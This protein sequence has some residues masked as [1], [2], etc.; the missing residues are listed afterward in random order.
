MRCEPLL[1]AALGRLTAVGQLCRLWHVPVPVVRK[2]EAV[3]YTKAVC[4]KSSAAH[5]KKPK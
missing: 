2:V 5:C 3:S 4:E 1:S